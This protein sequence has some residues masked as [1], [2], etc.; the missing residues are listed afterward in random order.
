MS[1]SQQATRLQSQN[2]NE[3]VSVLVMLGIYS[4]LISLNVPVQV[5][6][7]CF[8]CFVIISMALVIH[9]HKCN[10]AE[11]DSLHLIGEDKQIH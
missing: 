1:F 9:W 3:N 2:L 4:L 11:Y 7:L 10:Q 5:V 8:G 6:I